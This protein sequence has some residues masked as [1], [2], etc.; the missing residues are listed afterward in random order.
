MNNFA[1]LL[2]FGGFCV[3]QMN[4]IKVRC[5]A[6]SKYQIKTSYDLRGRKTAMTDSNF[7]NAGT[8]TWNYK[9]LSKVCLVSE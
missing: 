1:M 5:N 9:S 7:G 4:Y 2:R 6:T 3:G 8:G